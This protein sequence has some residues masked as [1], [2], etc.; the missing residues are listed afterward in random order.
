[1]LQHLNGKKNSIGVFEKIEFLPYLSP[2]N[3]SQHCSERN[4]LMKSRIPWREKLEKITD[5]KIVDV[6]IK[7]QKQYGWGKMIIAKPL[8][9]DALIRK[10]RKGKLVT[11]QLLREKLARDYAETHNGQEV[12]TCPLTT[13]IF[14]RIISECANED[15]QQG[16]KNVTPYWR[17]VKDDGSLFEK[18]PGGINA[19]EKKLSSEGCTFERKGK[20]LTVQN[21]ASKLVTY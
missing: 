13:G 16:K 1:M 12:V 9:V 2:R 11:V 7:W 19:Q 5:V 4:N 20:K 6:P 17:V 14:V 18:F 15:I 10:V 3:F 21:F 8:D